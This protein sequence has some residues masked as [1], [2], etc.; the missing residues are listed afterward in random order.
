[1]LWFFIKCAWPTADEIFETLDRVIKR[2]ITGGIRP[3]S[4]IL[5]VNDSTSINV[6]KKKIERF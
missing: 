3:I 2:R 6:R 4:C 1:M 5:S